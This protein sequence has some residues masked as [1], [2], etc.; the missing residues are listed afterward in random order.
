MTKRTILL[1]GSL[2]AACTAVLALL[3]ALRVEPAR[4]MANPAGDGYD[5]GADE[6]AVRHL[7]LPVA[8]RQS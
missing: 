8:L 1:A 7:Y 2:L 4:A 3:W 5:I 6:L